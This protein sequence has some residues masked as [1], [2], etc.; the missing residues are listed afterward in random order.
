MG[1]KARLSLTRPARADHAQTPYVILPLRAS[2]PHLQRSSN[3]LRFSRRALHPNTTNGNERFSTGHFFH[4]SGT[5]KAMGS[6][7]RHFSR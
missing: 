7:F 1:I 4:P 6:G 2:V 3:G 5:L